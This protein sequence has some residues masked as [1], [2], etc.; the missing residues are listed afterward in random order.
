VS[1][2]RSPYADRNGARATR[3]VDPRDVRHP[4]AKNIGPA[5]ERQPVITGCRSAFE[6]VEG[7]KNYRSR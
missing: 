5:A 1:G 6:T 4:L 2:Q 3:H 7:E